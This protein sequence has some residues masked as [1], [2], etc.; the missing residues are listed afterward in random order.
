MQSPFNRRRMC[1]VPCKHIYTLLMKKR[2]T[3]YLPFHLSYQV[4][5]HQVG[6]DP[7]VKNEATSDNV[8]ILD[9]I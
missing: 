5:L 7:P 9:T 2:K 8:F 6:Q 4:F 3:H 1:T